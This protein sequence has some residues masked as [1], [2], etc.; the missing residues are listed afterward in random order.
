MI[1]DENSAF[2]AIY[3]SVNNDFTYRIEISGATSDWFT[4][5][6]ILPA[7]PARESIMEISPPAYAAGILAKQRAEGF[8]SF[9]CW[10]YGKVELNLKFSRPVVERGA[11]L[12]W[13]TASVGSET[14][15][16]VYLS[17]APDNLSGTASIQLKENGILKLVTVAERNGKT[18]TSSRTDQC[19]SHSRCSAPIRLHSGS[20]LS[21]SPCTSGP[22]PAN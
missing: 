15:Q 6:V 5:T 10:Q 16:R 2:H 1:A 7:E 18:L 17:L 19:S 11:Y 12:E 14:G 21:S 3:P 20:V 9:G 22:V 4:V 8:E 13:R